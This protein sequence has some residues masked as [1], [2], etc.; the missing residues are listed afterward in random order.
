MLMIS[1]AAEIRRNH[2]RYM[3]ECSRKFEGK[4][5]RNNEIQ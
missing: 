1:L 3:K 2:K 5:V 4:G